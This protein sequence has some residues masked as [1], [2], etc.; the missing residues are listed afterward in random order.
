RRANFAAQ[1]QIQRAGVAEMEVVINLQRQR[2]I[3]SGADRQLGGRSISRNNQ[4]F[5]GRQMN[6]FSCGGALNSAA[7]TG[8]TERAIL[9]I[10]DM[11]S[12]TGLMLCSIPG[13]LKG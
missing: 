7:H 6:E 8:A 3:V 5:P 11:T 10:A 2:E 1:A 9:S 4:P 13:P 12:E